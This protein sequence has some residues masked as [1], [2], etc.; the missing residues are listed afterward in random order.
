MWYVNGTNTYSFSSIIYIYPEIRR[1]Y[2]K[3]FL[4]TDLLEYEVGYLIQH[5]VWKYQMMLELYQMIYLKY[6]LAQET[7]HTPVPYMFYVYT[8]VLEYRQLLFTTA[9][10]FMNWRRSTQIEKRSLYSTTWHQ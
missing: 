5:I 10:C 4:F 8:N 6:F 9:T 3:R 1:Y 2:E 7:A